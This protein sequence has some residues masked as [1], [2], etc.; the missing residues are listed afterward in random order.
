[1]PAADKAMSRHHRL[2]M[3]FCSALMASCATAGAPSDAPAGSS[4]A[5]PSV[6]APGIVGEWVGFHDCERIVTMLTE[7][8]LDEFI[9]EQVVELV[10]GAATPEDIDPADPCRGAVPREHSHFFTADGEFGSRDFNGQQVD[11]GTYTLEGDDI[12]VING[13]TFHYRI[14][15]DSISFVPDPVDISGCTT[16]MCRFRATW[17]LGVAMPGTTW[18][19]GTISDQ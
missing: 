4:S 10:P 1:M 12:V 16:K 14:D 6:D 13:E 7:A 9:L 2:S 8:N 11:E 19:R 17:V 5:A 3:L 15:G 18:T